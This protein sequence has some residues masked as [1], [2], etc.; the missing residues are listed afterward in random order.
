MV[1]LDQSHRQDACLVVDALV[2]KH[3]D[4]TKCPVTESIE[5]FFPSNMMIKFETTLS[6]ETLA[7]NPLDQDSKLHPGKLFVLRMKRLAEHLSRC[8]LCRHRFAE[9]EDVGHLYSVLAIVNGVLSSFFRVWYPNDN[10]S[11]I[12][13]FEFGR[14][15]MP[16]EAKRATRR[17][18]RE[19]N[20]EVKKK[21]VKT[22]R[23]EREILPMRKKLMRF[24]INPIQVLIHQLKEQLYKAAQQT[25]KDETARVPNKIP[26]KY[27]NMPIHEFL[28]SDPPIDLFE[29]LELLEVG[30]DSEEK[31]D[32]KTEETDSAID[33]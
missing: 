17:V 2:V 22:Y 33:H 32:G 23:K 8:K 5:V 25:P 21:G 7:A 1:V 31:N 19:R 18:I 12:L 15:I 14:N 11:E 24:Y 26:A 3:G 16:V 30:E 9:L 29:T 13:K 4:E 6:K 27:H 28:S 20:R 10:T